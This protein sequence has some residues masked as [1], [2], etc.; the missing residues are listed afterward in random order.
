M[1][2][3]NPI[4]QTISTMAD[5]LHDPASRALRQLGATGAADFVDGVKNKQNA[6][7]DATIDKVNGSDKKKKQDMEEGQRIAAAGAASAADAESKRLALAESTRIEDE[8]MSAG[9]K[10]RTLLTGPAGLE[11]EEQSISRRTLRAGV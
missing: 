9:S 11:D 6:L 2:K 1:G 3:K 10:S 8:R 7:G 5:Y 4:K